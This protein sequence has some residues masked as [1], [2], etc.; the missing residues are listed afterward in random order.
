MTTTIDFNNLSTGTVV[1]NEY[2]A[3]GVTVTATG[4]SGQAMIFDTANPTGFDWDLHTNNLGKALI[5]SEDGH[6]H[7][8]DDNASGGTFHFAFDNATSVATTT[9]NKSSASTLKAHTAWT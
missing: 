7:D 3:Q 1:D 2:Q 8:P 9:A 6:S 5:I 4:G